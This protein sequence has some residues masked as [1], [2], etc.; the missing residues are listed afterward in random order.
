MQILNH[1]DATSVADAVA[2]LNKYGSSAK[3]MAGGTE[4]LH[5]LKGNI[6]PNLPSYIINIKTIPGL[7]TIT[8][9]SS[10]LT[11]GPLATLNSVATNSN[12]LSTYP[13]LAQ[14]ASAVATNQI[15]NLGT[16]GG[17]ISQEVWCWYYRWEHN[18]FYCL[19]KGG[20]T[21]YAQ[22]G[23]NTFHSIFGGPGGC[24]SVH[25]SDT[26]IA[27]LALNASIVTSS[28]TIPISQFFKNI[29]P[30]NVLANNEIITAID[31]PTPPANALQVFTKFRFKQSFDFA[32]VSVGL[33]AAPTTGSVTT[34]NIWLGGVGPVPM[35]ATG[36]ETALKGNAIS[37]TVATAAG[38][39]AIANAVPLTYNHY[40]KNIVSTLVSRAIMSTT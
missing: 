31:V 36:A 12:V 33:L 25:P 32:V 2:Q 17:N 29:S 40:K 15:R 24:Y 11:I 13:M 7:N 37:S 38:A 3:V 14:A 22:S 23:V 4:L 6:R 5:T 9:T 10:G 8:T 26:A 19:R 20:S 30:G 35:E 27:L 18:Q 39:A 16:I 28:R 21:C 1:Y 34:A